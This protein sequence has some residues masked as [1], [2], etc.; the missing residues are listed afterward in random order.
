MLSLLELIFLV[1]SSHFFINFFFY[2][3]VFF[4]PCW[5]VFTYSS[6]HDVD[7][8]VC[9]KCHFVFQRPCDGSRCSQSHS[10]KSKKHQ[11]NLSLRRGQDKSKQ[12]L[13][14]STAFAD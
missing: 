7:E 4:V 13:L 1:N 2:W 14:E 9:V 6:K 11:H 12:N 10:H 8:R 3:I 5:I